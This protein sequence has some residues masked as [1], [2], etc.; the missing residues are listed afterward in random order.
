[1]ESSVYQMRRNFYRDDQFEKRQ[2]GDSQ[3]DDSQYG[4]PQYRDTQYDDHQD[5]SPQYRD[6]Q[7]DDHQY[8]GQ[9]ENHQHKDT[10]YDAQYEDG[11]SSNRQATFVELL[12]KQSDV[13][14]KLTDRV[15]NVGMGQPGGYDYEYK[16]VY[17]EPY[18]YEYE[19]YDN[20]VFEDPYYSEGMGPGPMRVG[21]RGIGP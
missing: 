11:P 2:Y 9:Y 7:Y 3:Y 10:Q 13:I 18:S 14:D 16:E 17:E 8:D 20:S 21:G 15:S 1:M 5:G 12:R 6:I 19:T 4:R